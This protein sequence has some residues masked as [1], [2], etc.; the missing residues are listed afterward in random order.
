MTRRQRQRWNKKQAQSLI[1]EFGDA[2]VD[3]F[4]ESYSVTGIRPKTST[5]TRSAGA[6]PLAPVAPLGVHVPV[7][8]PASPTAGLLASCFH[9]NSILL[10][11]S[12]NCYTL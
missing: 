9:L 6:I 3:D 5:P 2:G 12:L 1:R 7:D 11:I 4:D 8:R 10:S